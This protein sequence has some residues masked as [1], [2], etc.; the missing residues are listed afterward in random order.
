MR[1]D[2]T[3]IRTKYVYF[4]VFEFL[5][6]ED[7]ITIIK[8]Y[9]FMILA[10]ITMIGHPTENSLVPSGIKFYNL[11]HIILSFVHHRPSINMLL[12]NFRSII[13]IINY[14]LM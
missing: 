11:S 3:Y 6:S 1:S 2:V 10:Y 8:N 5:L 7:I 4:D 14:I 9:C 12:P 13:I